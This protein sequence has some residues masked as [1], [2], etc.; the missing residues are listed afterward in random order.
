MR[1]SAFRRQ[2]GAAIDVPFKLLISVVIVTM[3]TA[4]LFPALQAYQR[5]EMEHRLA[6]TLAEIEAAV[7]SVHHHPG[8]SRT[9]VIDVP[10]SGVITLESM[11]IGGGLTAPPAEVSTI[12]WRLSSGTTGVQL[13]STTSGP[14]PM[15]STE[16]GELVIDRFPCLIILE[17]KVAPPGGHY[18]TFVQVAVL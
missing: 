8:S 11:S 16:Y 4:I 18:S 9:V 6:L 17:A 15:A 7:I 14:I 12:G 1:P 10:S 13:V 5:S 2:T 3:A